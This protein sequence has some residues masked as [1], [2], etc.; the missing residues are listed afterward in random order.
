MYTT[1]R[2]ASKE[3]IRF[4][5]LMAERKKERF[6]NRNKKTINE[7]VEIART[8]GD[9]HIYI[10]RERKGI[11]STISE[12]LI[13]SNGGWRWDKTKISCEKSRSK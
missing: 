6:L 9:E 4:A 13:N 10:I 11:P 3:T 12:I 5:Q 2:Y 7:M 8:S 1:S